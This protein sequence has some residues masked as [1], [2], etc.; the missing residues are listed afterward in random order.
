MVDSVQETEER[1]IPA[2]LPGTSDS[3]QVRVGEQ[4]AQLLEHPGWQAVIHALHI[5]AEDLLTSR[6]LRK[7]DVEAA[8][9]ADV[10]GHIRGLKE[11]VPFALG[12]IQNGREVAEALR[13]RDG[14]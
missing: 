13:E 5:R 4:V 2:A 6:V 1:V 12:L 9:Y 10:V 11:V 14:S 3:E 7:T 8:P